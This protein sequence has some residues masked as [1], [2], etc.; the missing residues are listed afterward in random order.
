MA[1]ETK[2]YL[3]NIES[4]LKEY[5]DQ[6]ILAKEKLADA[7]LAVDNLQKGQF[8]S[9]EEIELTNTALRDAQ[10]EY[11]NAKKVVDLAT[12]ANKAQSGSYEQLYKQWQLAQTQLKLMSGAYEK[13]SSGVMVLSQ[14]YTQQSVVV[15]NAKKALDQFGK[16]IND[17]RLNVGNYS[18]AIEGALGKISMIPGPVGNAASS[19]SMFTKVLA[20]VNPVFLAIGAG[21]VGVVGA[22][23]AP[24]IAFLK[25]SQDG[26][27]TLAQ[28]TNGWKAAIVALKGELVLAGK[29]MTEGP[30]AEKN[31]NRIQN[32]IDVIKKFFT[33]LTGGLFT[34]VNELTGATAAWDNL[35]GKINDAAKSAELY[36]KTNQELEK[37]ENNLIVARAESNLKLKEARL[38][39]SDTTKTL[40]ERLKALQDSMTLEN[41]TADDE[42]SLNNKKAANELTNLNRLKA[43]GQDTRADEKK[44]QELI[45]QGI[46]LRADSVGREVR[47]SLRIRSLKAEILADEYKEI[48]AYE[49]LDELQS[50]MDVDS[51]KSAKTTS[52][53]F[54]EEQLLELGHSYDEREQMHKDYVARD[55]AID[56]AIIQEQKNVLKEQMDLQL[57]QVD[58]II[59]PEY[60]ANAQRLVIKKSYDEAYAQLDIQAKADQEKRDLDEAQRKNKIYT[61]DVKS[62]DD[63]RKLSID[64]RQ[65][66]D[67]QD[68]K[69]LNDLLDAEH[70]VM[71]S[72]IEWE[73][74]SDAKKY[75]IEQQYNAAKKALSLARVEQLNEER[76]V[77]ADAF[78]AMADI[79]GK[80][81]VV[82]KMMGIA[83]ATINTW[84]AASKALAT[85]PPPFSY[86]AMAAAIVA[87][88]ETIANIVKVKVPS[89]D[90]TDSSSMP[91]SLSVQH[92]TASP[93]GTSILQ[94]QMSQQQLN[95]I[96]N[97]GLLSAADIAAAIAKEFSKMKPPV[98]T[99]EDINAKIKSVNKVVVRANI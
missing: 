48:A 71:L 13:N 5:I 19:V 66:G 39:Y 18:A 92:I 3:V 36:T 87:G 54:Y 84:I 43:A 20:G 38:L 76:Q 86:I 31:Y 9:R 57:K 15:A 14:K 27:D 79:L 61:D 67:I 35:K 63:A 47:D 62:A 23:T 68:L 60:L 51:M 69:A 83:Q 26:M 30:A 32:M 85:Y 17:N 93:A 16:G 33:V 78:G 59:Q 37:E 44:Y 74:A 41:K 95:A 22:I 73:S 50:K 49:K 42:I 98:V 12:Q 29:E 65:V 25:W 52:K 8:K 46:N 99:V 34:N 64:N 4:N 70:S 7:K 80:N 58:T 89:K 45:A 82:G 53:N 90:S 10:K 88:L 77:V 81:T 6:L 72:S 75:L 24:M 96:P 94:P 28:K 91:S 40:E 21:I 97:T 2:T 56:A 55:A 1:D 11:T